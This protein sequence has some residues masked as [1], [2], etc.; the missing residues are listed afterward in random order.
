[1]SFPVFSETEIPLRIFNAGWEAVMLGRE[2][3]PGTP[4]RLASLPGTCRCSW[5][6]HEG[7]QVASSCLA[8]KAVD[9]WPL[10]AG[11]VVV[12]LFTWGSSRKL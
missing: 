5:L 2:A 11:K 3:S 9:N 1:M 12:P 6:E 10:P 4:P 7:L 8:Q